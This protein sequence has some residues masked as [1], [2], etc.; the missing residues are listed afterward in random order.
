MALGKEYL[1][2]QQLEFVWPVWEGGYAWTDHGKDKSGIERPPFLVPV[3][4]ESTWRLTTPLQDWEAKLKPVD[5]RR[6]SP[7]FKEFARVSSAE[8]MRRFADKHGNLARGVLVVNDSRVVLPQFP[9]GV[10]RQ[11]WESEI[12]AVK[13]AEDLLDRL[14]DNTSLKSI[15]QWAANKRTVLVQMP[16]AMKSIRVD[17][18]AELEKV[19]VGN[20]TTPATMALRDFINSKMLEHRCVPRA[21]CQMKPAGWSRAWS[22]SS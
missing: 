3:P 9:Y 16:F 11:F 13:W 14:D 5:K 10:S 20:R 18:S 17:S 2:L 1:D 21:Y 6:G 19:R 7:L 4:T 22:R 15:V 8:D 12:A